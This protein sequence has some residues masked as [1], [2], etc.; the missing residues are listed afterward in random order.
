MSHLSPPS[1]LPPGSSVWAY[2]RD[3]GGPGQDR[4]VTQQR[5]AI[6]EYCREYNLV[7]AR[8]PF[9]DIHRS[10]GSTAGR[11]AFD[12][13]IA[14]SATESL[15]PDG[16]LIWNFARFAR[17]V[18]DSH[19]Y[20]A[21]IRKRG[22]VIHSLSDNIPE[23]PFGPVIETLIHV[24]DEQKKHEASLGAQRGLHSLVRQG[25]MPGIPPKGFK[26]EPI[27][28]ISELGIERLSHRWV[29]DPDLVPVIQKAWTMR[30]AGASLAE[31]SRQTNLYKSLNCYTT[32]FANP[33]YIGQLH[34][35]DQVF[36]N[37]CDPIIDMTT[38]S[39]VQLMIK[40]HAAR[41]NVHAADQHHP[42]RS[43]SSFLLSGLL[44]CGRCKSPL[45]GQNSPQKGGSIDFS[46]RCSGGHRK[47]DCALPRIPA[48]ALEQAI[49]TGLQEAINHAVLIAEIYSA[50]KQLN[51]S[52]TIDQ[53]RRRKEML[54][55]RA[56]IRSQA[57]RLT[58][59]IAEAGHSRL[60][61]EKLSSLEKDLI[62]VETELAGTKRQVISTPMSP[63]QVVS[64][65][66]NLKQIVE[67]LPDIQQ[68]Q[69]ILRQYISAIRVDRHD[70]HLVIQ[71]DIFYPGEDPPSPFQFDP[72]DNETVSLIQHPTGALIF[73]HSF[74]FI[75]HNRPHHR[76]KTAS[77]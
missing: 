75:I 12:Q 2:L 29:P 14:L 34:Y 42:R 36:K 57:A 40:K 22:I 38:W 76:K 48:Y 72:G 51:E 24:S 71:M 49:L 45:Y 15:R 65:L 43:T 63:D 4:S 30:A 9:E 11:F 66:G 16:I 6:I 8:P 20:K 32:F 44:F 58:D 46:Y 17:D 31:I 69:S 25:A 67:A 73:S 41:Q 55:Q 18:D 50:A 60:M 21:L 77:H 62:G 39:A 13:M 59:A 52:S 26:T 23:G 35:G 74:K 64:R 68:R 27:T 3:S 54:S 7:L 10:G 61:L 33:I 37:Y 19:F 56:R 1:T 5:D 28:T 47:R 70:H 53:D